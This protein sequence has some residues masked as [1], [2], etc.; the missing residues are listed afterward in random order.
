M[1]TINLN[2]V[3]YECSLPQAAYARYREQLVELVK[4]VDRPLERFV[5]KLGGVSE[6]DRATAIAAF[7]QRPDWDKPPEY[8]LTRG[9]CTDKGCTLLMFHCLTP[10]PDAVTRKAIVDADVDDT[11]HSK[12]VRAMQPTPAADVLKHT[13]KLKEKLRCQALQ[14]SQGLTSGPTA[15]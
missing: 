4:T 8:M 10:T 11:L 7:V 14:E 13:A 9:E 1:G 2:G 15:E 3:D 12:L 5:A 6:A